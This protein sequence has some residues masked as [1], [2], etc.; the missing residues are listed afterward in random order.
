MLHRVALVRRDVSEEISASIIRVAR[1]GD[2]V[3]TLAVTHG[4]SFT[5]HV[6][7]MFVPHRK[8][9]YGP[10]RPVTGI[11]LFPYV[12]DVCT[13]QETHLRAVTGIALLQFCTSTEPT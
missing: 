10:P 5:F 4:D 13:S 8:H 3:T 9:A 11:D 1:I 12:D 2:L 6:Y 7:M